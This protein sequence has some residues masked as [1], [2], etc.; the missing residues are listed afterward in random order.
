MALQCARCRSYALNPTSH[1]RDP[2]K[3]LDL[4][5][6]C[7]W[8]AEYEQSHKLVERLKETLLAAQSHL[9]Y[10]GYGD[11]WERECAREE[12]LE[13]RINDALSAAGAIMEDAKKEEG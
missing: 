11:K 2:N 1:G 6:V 12:K 8:R 9:D 5:D 4:C 3:H 7:Y 10:C 13:E